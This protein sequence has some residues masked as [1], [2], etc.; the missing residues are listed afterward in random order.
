[1]Y[2]H[3]ISG[4]HFYVHCTRNG[5][6]PDDADEATENLEEQTAEENAF[7]EELKKIWAM[8]SM[9]LDDDDNISNKKK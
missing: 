8:E 3:V 4:T 1:M 2:P 9:A 5:I 6:L 7:S